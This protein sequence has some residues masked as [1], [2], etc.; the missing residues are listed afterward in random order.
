MGILLGVAAIS[1]LPL[2]TPV[3]PPPLDDDDD[4]D[5]EDDGPDDDVPA[6][7]DADAA[8]DGDDLTAC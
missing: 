7:A 8:E 3:V 6:V 5:D 2:F 4:D 1:S